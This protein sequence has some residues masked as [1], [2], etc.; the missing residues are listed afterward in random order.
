[1]GTIG[2]ALG[3]AAELIVGLDSQ[4][5]RIVGLSVGV[6]LSAVLIAT[7]IGLPMGATIAVARFP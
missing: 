1:M 2:L 3:Q 4:L 5:V 6:S 7:L